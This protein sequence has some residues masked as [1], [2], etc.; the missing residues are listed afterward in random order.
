MY[1]ST[2]LHAAAA[3][4]RCNI[5]KIFLAEEGVDATIADGDG[6]TPLHKACAFGCADCARAL[7]AKAPAAL[8]AVNAAGVTPAQARSHRRR[9]CSRPHTVVLQL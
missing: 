9:G 7:V 4:G 5:V 6:C 2:A 8:T 1:G 3:L